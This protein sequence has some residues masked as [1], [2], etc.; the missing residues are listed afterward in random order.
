MKCP[1]IDV[2]MEGRLGF[3]DIEKFGKEKASEIDALKQDVEVVL[4]WNLMM[5]MNYVTRLQK[6]WASR[7]CKR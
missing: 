4:I 6:R 2:K 5:Q 7:K 3:S 1:K